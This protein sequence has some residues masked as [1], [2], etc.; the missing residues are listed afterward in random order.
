MEI[1]LEI[2]K[3]VSDFFFDKSKTFFRLS[4]KRAEQCLLIKAFQQ[5]WIG[6]YEK[7]YTEPLETIIEEDTEEIYF[8]E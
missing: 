2:G 3:F 8:S 4:E 6:E 7:A 1:S 5:S